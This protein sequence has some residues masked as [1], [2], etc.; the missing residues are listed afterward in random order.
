MCLLVFFLS[1]TLPSPSVIPSLTIV[2]KLQKDTMRTMTFSCG[3]STRAIS[4]WLVLIFSSVSY[5]NI[6][7]H[8]DINHNDFP[9]PNA[10]SEITLGAYYYP[11]HLR[12]FQV[13]REGYLRRALEPRQEIRLGEYDDTQAQVIQQHLDWSHQANIKVWISSWWG[14]LSDTDNAFKNVIL[15][16]PGLANY[17]HKV[18]LLYETTGRI[19][20][21]EEYDPWRVDGDIDY[22]CNDYV[23]HPN[24]FRINGRPVLVVYLTRLLENRGVLDIVMAKIRDKC[25]ELYVIGDQVWGDPPDEALD[26]L[27]AVTNYDIY[28]NMGKPTFAG[29][30]GV[31]SYYAKA[32]TW[33]DH[34]NLHNA[35][36]V[37][38]VSPGYNDR[39]I[40]LQNDNPALS[41]S[42]TETSSEGSLLAAQLVAAIQLLDPDADH[43]LLV[44]SFNEVS[45]N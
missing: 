31:D 30:S 2:R 5:A 14:P 25:P 29:Q 3:G 28:G 41:R 12:H 38:S 45:K 16:H 10:P 39:G 8:N 4:W 44:N 20:K 34:A 7:L 40:R 23:D 13:T 27:D 35:S 6:F 9:L 15:P 19:K 1:T 36:F 37:P 42:L 32:T 22:I 26:Q 17:T 21:S 33:K 11:W 18:A 43:L 24:Y